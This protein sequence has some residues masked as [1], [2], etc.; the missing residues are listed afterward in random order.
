[1]REGKTLVRSLHFET[2]E[3]EYRYEH[4]RNDSHIVL[5]QFAIAEKNPP[6]TRRARI[7]ELRVQAADL[8]GQA[9]AKAQ[10]GDHTGAIETLVDSTAV[11]LEAIRL[12]GV[13]VP[14]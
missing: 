10:A 13:W 7:E 11:L 6:E 9:E 3:A 2:A 8:R 5:L 14:G 4:D 1:M 12:S